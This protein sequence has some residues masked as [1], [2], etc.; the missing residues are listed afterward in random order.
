M[1]KR[2][3]IAPTALKFLIKLFLLQ[4]DGRKTGEK[5]MFSSVSQG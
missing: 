5:V 2:I 3:C 1:N 4:K